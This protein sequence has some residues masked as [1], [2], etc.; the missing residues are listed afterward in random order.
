MMANPLAQKF[1]LPNSTRLN[2][3]GQLYDGAIDFQIFSFVGHES[4]S[5][6]LLAPSILGPPQRSI[7]LRMLFTPFSGT[8]R[9]GTAL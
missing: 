3:F 8:N 9:L 1:P 6:F 2:E 5:P 7:F 4:L